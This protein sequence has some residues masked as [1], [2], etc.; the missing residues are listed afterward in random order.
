M[1]TQST[2]LR[3]ATNIAAW[4]R[5]WPGGYPRYAVTSD[6]GALCPACC[7]AERKSIGTTTGTDG[8][9]VVADDINWENP[10]LH[11]DHCRGRIESAYAD[12]N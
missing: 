10:D 5:T 1:T 12:I 8:W 4:P 11:C 3:L 6:G 7:K 2:S 9:C